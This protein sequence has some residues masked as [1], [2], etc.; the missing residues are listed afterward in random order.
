MAAA[1]LAVLVVSALVAR[2]GWVGPV[3]RRVFHAINDLPD[4]LY[5]PMW[6]FQQFGNIVVALGVVLIIALVLRRPALAGAAVLAVVAKLALERVVKALVERSRP[7]T[8]IGDI[9]T[10][11]EVPTQGLSFVSG[12]AVISTACATMLMAVLPSRWRPIPWVIVVLNGVAR[13]HVGAHNP[14][15]VVGGIGLGLVIGGLLYS[16]L[17][18]LDGRRPQ[19]ATTAAQ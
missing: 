18:L 9:V 6:V 3:E 15:D 10:R 7:G 1:G 17:V 16:A 11:G 12:H 2:N 4:W 5:R 19:P 14:L 8:S 13:V